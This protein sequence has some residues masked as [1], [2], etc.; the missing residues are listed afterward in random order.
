MH[1]HKHLLE[2]MKS[3]G[4]DDKE[5]EHASLVFQEHKPHH[6]IIH[7]IWDKIIHWLVFL[8][9][10]I[11]KIL[12]FFFLLPIFILFE[13]IP[14]YVLISLTGVVFGFL[15]LIVINNMTHLK[16][17][18]H[19][20]LSLIIPLISI[21]TIL[22]MMYIIQKHFTLFNTLFKEPLF[23]STLYVCSFM[24]PYYISRIYYLSRKNI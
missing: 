15:F 21:V 5:L 9:I 17:H 24:V 13:G 1:N 14:K 22:S 10:P 20:I 23:V 4:W 7:P 18:H 8:L 3:K 11:S 19:A 2:R 6:H 16:S 12:L